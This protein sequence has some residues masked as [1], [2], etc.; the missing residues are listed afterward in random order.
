MNSQGQGRQRRLRRKDDTKVLSRAETKVPKEEIK[1]VQVQVPGFDRRRG[2]RE[3]KGGLNNNPSNPEGR[4]RLDSWIG[5]RPRIQNPAL[6]FKCHP[7]K[8]KRK[9]TR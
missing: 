7:W 3:E 4:D 1:D 5:A 2:R 6:G 8:E 9:L